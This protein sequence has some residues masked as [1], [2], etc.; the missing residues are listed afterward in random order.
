VIAASLVLLALVAGVIGTTL[1]LLAANRAT[2]AE[3][4]AK[5]DALEQKRL[6]ERAAE[7]ERLASGEHAKAVTVFERALEKRKALL[8]PDH[9]HTLVSTH[10]LA[11]AYLVGGQLAKAVPLFEEAL[12]KQKPKL[13]SDHPQTRPVKES[14][15]F[16]RLLDSKERYARERATKGPKHIDTLL[17]LRGVAQMDLAF[18]QPDLAEPLLVEVLDGLAL[19]PDDPIRAFTV[20]LLQQ[21]F[22]LRAETVPDCWSTFNTQSLLGGALL[23]QQKYAEAEPLLL[24]GYEGMRARE[25][26]IP[27]TDGGELRIPEALD[28]LIELY[29]ATNK[30]EE[31]KRWRTERA[32]Y[33]E[34][35][36]TGEIGRQTD[37]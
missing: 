37:E 22:D 24:T 30:P 35:R 23:G 11:L 5:N 10:D 31:A 15:A 4:I 17:A 19:G 9:P 26:M 6:A 28:R 3:R 18:G 27:R 21:T 33:P 29:T 2:E 12:Q 34:T 32:K 14:P 7:R 8:G 20:G 36:P 16:A 13:S 1:G 25:A